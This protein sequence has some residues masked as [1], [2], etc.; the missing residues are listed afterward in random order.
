MCKLGVKSARSTLGPDQMEISVEIL[1][2]THPETIHESDTE[3]LTDTP[4]FSKDEL[5]RTVP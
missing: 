3:T 2:S 1:F 5:S 4:L